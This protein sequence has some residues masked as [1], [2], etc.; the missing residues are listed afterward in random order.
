MPRKNLIFICTDQMRYDALSINGN[1]TVDTTHIDRIGFEGMVFHRH[2]TPNQICSPSRATMATG[3]Y[4]RHHG[5]WRNG[6]TLDPGIPSLW[7]F[8]QGNGYSTHAS[9]KLHYQPLLAPESYRMPES[10]AFWGRGNAH[11]WHGPYYGF[12]TVDLVLGEANESTR[13]GHYAEWLKRHH[14][15][16]LRLYE[17]EASPTGRAPDL[18]E[19]WRSAVPKE[20]HYTSWITDRAI[21]FLQNTDGDKPFCLYVSYPDPHH[22]F[23]PPAPY[24][25]AY[26]PEMMPQPSVSPGELDLMP[27]Y[28]GTGDDPTADAYIPD[29]SPIREQGFLLRTDTISNETMARVIAHTFGMVKMIDDSVGRLIAALEETGR[30]EDTYVVFTSDHGELLGDHGLLRKGPPPYRQLLQ[31]PL[32]VSGPSIRRGSSTKA[33]TSHID[34][35]AT[36]AELLI[37]EVPS[38]DGISLAPLLVRSVE[39]VRDYLLA[40]YHPRKDPELYNQT[41]MSDSWRLTLYPNRS[42]WG[43]LF[44]LAIDPWEHRNLFHERAHG[45]TIDD[46]ARRLLRMMPSRP[47]LPNV[48]LGAY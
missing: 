16:A 18:T 25:D 48:P 7:A 26:D 21:D 4:P 36:I 34:L 9:G 33:L 5:V 17:P 46:L 47:T 43:E 27:A 41:I 28:L 2:H 13:A 11:N 30:K 19:L 23:T 6:V 15:E 32:L 29:G 10:L 3:L 35:F 45:A 22:P 12:D 1:R 38:T 39:H 24:A 20:L 42:G 31:V 8:L 37:G 40:E 14:P 44:N